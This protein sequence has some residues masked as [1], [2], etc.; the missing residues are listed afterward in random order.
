MSS[1][2]K[3]TCISGMSVLVGISYFTRIRPDHCA[4]V[5][6]QLFHERISE[7]AG[8]P[9]DELTVRSH[10]VDDGADVGHDDDL[11]HIDG[12]R[13]GINR[14]IDTAADRE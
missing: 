10:R 8:Y 9:T 11:R 6:H 4:V 1:S 7:A 3:T 13:F 14:E 2:I 12:S 5:E